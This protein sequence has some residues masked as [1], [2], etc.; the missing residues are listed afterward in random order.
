MRLE[1]AVLDDDYFFASMLKE[2]ILEWANKENMNFR[3]RVFTDPY[4]LDDDL[5]V[6]DLLFLDI[7][8]PDQDGVVW[9]QKWIATGRFAKIIYVSA[10][11]EQVF[12]TFQNNPMAYIRKS[13][14]KEDLQNGLNLFKKQ[15]F[16]N[17]VQVIIPEGK[18][19]HFF[20]PSDI[21]YLSSYKHYI[22]ICMRNGT[23]VVIREKM[24]R[25]EEILGRY[26]FIRIHTRYMV[27]VKYISY[28]KQSTIFMVSGNDYRISNKY[29]DNVFERL[30]LHILKEEE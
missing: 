14:L 23:K 16:S 15:L 28:I 21:E 20:I 27:N 11:D 19:Q 13:H 10:Y 25:M 30:K 8:L 22:D 4:V 26:G 6:Y 3:V 1:I 12:R 9:M 17:P 29:K 5:G 2:K 7:I 24:E 18:K